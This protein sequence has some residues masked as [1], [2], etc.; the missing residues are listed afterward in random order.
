[1][2]KYMTTK[3][4]YAT[5]LCETC[6][7]GGDCGDECVESSTCSLKCNCG[8]RMWFIGALG[9]VPKSTLCKRCGNIVGNPYRK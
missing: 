2:I 7:S 3:Q 6:R 8:E 5:F 9:N 4:A 1:M